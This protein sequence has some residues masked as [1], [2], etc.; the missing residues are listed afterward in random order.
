MKQRNCF[1]FTIFLFSLI[2][3]ALT[4]YY[5]NYQTSVT[6][7]LEQLET[8]QHFTPFR[9]PFSAHDQKEFQQIITSITKVAQKN[10]LNYLVKHRDATYPMHDGHLDYARPSETQAFYV[11]DLHKTSLWQNFNTAPQAKA[12]YTY[13]LLK[14]YRVT[15][16]P[17]T[18]VF[19]EHKNF[20]SIFLL[21]TVDP[22]KFQHFI[23][24]LKLTLE[25]EFK[26]PTRRADYQITNS[27]QLQLPT[28]NIDPN[29]PNVLNYLSVFIL[30]ALALYFLLQWQT[31][32]LYK[33]NGW[34]FGKI[35]VKFSTAPFLMLV[36]ATSCDLVAWTKKLDLTV[37]LAKQG[38]LFVLVGL[39]S[40]LLLLALYLVSLD[41]L[42]E[43]YFATTTFIL[44]GGAKLFLLTSLI[45]SLAPLGALFLDSYAA[46]LPK[47][48]TL[49]NYAEAFPRLIGSN[50]DDNSD[51][52]YSALKSVF[53]KSEKAGA[54]LLDDTGAS[55]AQPA[56][57][58]R[59]FTG[60]TVDLNYL[61]LYP[62]YDAHKKKIVI[63]PGTKQVVLIVPRT[64][65]RYVAERLAYE[66]KT[67]RIAKK[68][69][70]KILYSEPKYDHGFKHLI[71][72]RSLKNEIVNVISQENIAPQTLNF[73]TGLAQDTFLIPLKG[74]SPNK[75]YQK[76]RPILRQAGLLD[77]FPQFIRYDKGSLEE[78]RQSK[79]NLKAVFFTQIFLL[80]TVLALSFYS[81]LSFFKK[82]AYALGI[83]KAFGYSRF[84]NYWPY[85]ALMVLQYSL[86]PL[87]ANDPNIPKEI[88]FT[89][90]C[91]FFG[92]ELII[93][94]CF[95]SYLE[96]EA[97]KNVQ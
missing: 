16:R 88:Y 86:T 52:D 95:I 92:V 17:L 21:E 13:P 49:K 56:E 75:L 61:K 76:W 22:K 70:V 5:S 3:N 42:K 51:T 85:W 37:L 34:S 90:V 60:I 19:T 84:R 40:Y 8:S 81:L 77:N 1:L 65:K 35:F 9:V 45:I 48:P 59:A 29:L 94:N 62:L 64:K 47:T 78:L 46:T 53:Q 54:L 82:N 71:T 25:Q 50:S 55:Y 73:M 28:L 11:F 12:T 58:S 69:G 91:F 74:D 26:R 15:I 79:G 97:L 72:G 68:Y 41:E 6:M 36:L 96:R 38:L 23:A 87:F 7:A 44:M 57:V 80:L 30:I 43:R 20:E 24:Q 66:K 33:L 67:S 31:L 2:F 39:F 83:K 18:Q 89:L 63:A 93:M 32:R 4:V 14:D 27:A 10:N